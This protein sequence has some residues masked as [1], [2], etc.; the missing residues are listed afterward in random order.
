MKFLVPP[1]SSSLI[2]RCSKPLAGPGRELKTLECQ[3]AAAE[4]HVIYLVFRQVTKG[5]GKP[6]LAGKEVLV[7]AEDAG[8]ISAL[9]FRRLTAEK[10]LEV[11][12]DRG[13]PDTF[14]LSEAA[15]VNAIPV[16]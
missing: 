15:A 14:S 7:N 12:L 10:I 4:D 2:S 3:L 5:G 13:V 8:T 11:A 9:Q 1:G 6:L 16:Q